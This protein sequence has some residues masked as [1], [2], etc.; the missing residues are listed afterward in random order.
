MPAVRKHGWH[1]VPLDLP[2]LA[3]GVA[4]DTSS[5]FTYD[6]FPGDLGTYDPSQEFVLAAALT[7][8]TTVAAVATNNFAIQVSHYSSANV[9]K[10][11]ILLSN[12]AAG[13]AFTANTPVDLGV[14]VGGNLTNPTG[15]TLVTGWALAPGDSIV[16]KRVSNGTGQASP[17]FTV[18]VGMGSKA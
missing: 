15:V 3:A 13:L 14:V 8:D 12:A 2:A 10:N 5:L 11:Q 4:N 6:A 7:F 1:R 18:T 9:L 17:A 16:V